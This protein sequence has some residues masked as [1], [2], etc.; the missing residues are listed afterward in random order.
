M[1]TMN[2]RTPN[3]LI[4]ERSPYLQQHAY[5]PVD[6]HPWGAEAFAIAEREGKPIFLSIGYSTCHWCHV[7]ERESFEDEETA[8][9]LNE[10]F[11]P[12]KVDREERPDV[13]A[14]YMTALHALGEHG[15]WPL[16]AWLT[17]E[18]EPYYLGTYFPPRPMYGRPSFL[19]V[20]TELRRA[21]DDERDRV[22]RAAAS[23]ADAV[24]KGNNDTSS[25]AI[26]IDAENDDRV[27]RWSAF[28]VNAHARIAAT[29]DS[30]YGG[31]GSA[32][33]F[34]R[35]VQL[36]FL[37]H[38][39][40]ST[41]DPRPLEMAHTTLRQM[42]SGGMYDQLGG[43]F[44]RYSVDA[45]WRVPHFEKMLYDQGQLLSVL[46]DTYRI[47]GD[48][49]L[50]KTMRQTIDYV[51]RDLQAPDGG[52]F[53]AE[54]A[55]SEGEEGT[56]YVWTLKELGDLFDTETIELLRLRFGLSPNGNFEKGKNVLHTTL[57]FETIAEQTGRTL[58]DVTSTIGKALEK[59]LAYR[60]EQRE[61]PSRDEKIVT[62]WNGLLLSGLARAGDALNDGEIVATAQRLAR[63]IPA[64]MTVDGRLMRRMIDGEVRFSGYLEDYAFLIAGLLDLHQVDFDT[65]WLR[66][67]VELT[68]RA[69]ELFA[70]GEGGGFFMTAPDE[71]HLL[72]RPRNDYDGAEPSGTSVMA[73]NMA[74][75]GEML[76]DAAMTD[77]AMATVDRAVATTAA[78]PDAIPLM[79]AVALRLADPPSSLII[80]RAAGD[81]EGYARLREQ[82]RSRYEPGRSVLIVDEKGPDPFLAEHAPYL[83]AVTPLDGRSVAY[84]CHDFVCEAPV[85]SLERV[86]PLSGGASVKPVRT[87]DG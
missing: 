73:M 31:F 71:P 14:I 72:L 40:A 43:G 22:L 16:S 79:A 35:P 80:A 6:W 39:H 67:A 24:R 56:F 59:M 29:Y 69:I 49:L 58:D 75:I 78:Y 37:L 81:D 63:W 25:E 38:Y 68:G 65:T 86:S 42:A 34:P 76:G 44:A 11:V 2:D 36:E 9:Q 82:V 57:P 3:R 53:A 7:M 70:D 23:I 62:A 64:A 30:R 47:T 85:D 74:R 77:R 87:T 17:P 83:D 19:Q 52:F 51:Q 18:L 55:D 54:D 15:G 45:E 48:P 13:D 60:G 1:S 8:R 21:W 66:S 27:D 12:I 4:D 46:A 41:G 5:N 32:P 20:L 84:R 26:A 50:A 10:M 33:K 61:R 28:A